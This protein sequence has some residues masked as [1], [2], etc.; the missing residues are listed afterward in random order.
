[1]IVKVI[2]KHRNS[3]CFNGIEQN[4]SEMRNQNKILNS[5]SKTVRAEDTANTG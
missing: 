3:D 4:K 2:N 1:M 5:S